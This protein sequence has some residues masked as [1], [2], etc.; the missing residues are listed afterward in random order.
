[1]GNLSKL[2][3]SSRLERASHY[4]GWKPQ[5]QSSR[6]R[7]R[8]HT[9]RLRL[10]S[11]RASQRQLIPEY[12]KQSFIIRL[13]LVYRPFFPQLI[14]FFVDTQLKAANFRFIN[15]LTKTDILQIDI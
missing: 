2:Q 15:E 11:L 5:E 9:T 14:C 3:V 8:N 10:Q 6:D 1:M 13:L 7:R 12:V 4:I